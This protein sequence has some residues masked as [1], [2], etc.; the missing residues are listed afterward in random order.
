M[1]TANPETARLQKRLE[2]ER[3]ARREAEALAEKGLRDLYEAQRKVQLLRDIADDANQSVAFEEAIKAAMRRVCTFMDWPLGHAYFLAPSPPRLVSRRI[4]YL[5]EPE[6]FTLFRRISEEAHFAS[7][8]GL[9]GRVLESGQPLW[10]ADVTREANFPRARAAVDI[11][12]RAA[13]AFPVRVGTEVTAVLEFF[14]AQP[15]E[16]AATVLEVMAHIGNQLGPVFKRTQAEK[17]LRGAYAELDERVQERTAE[18]EQANASLQEEIL[19]RKRAEEEEHRAR[20]LAEAAN[21]AKSAFLANMSHELRTPMNAII[22]FSEVLVDETFGELNAKQK[23]YVHNILS[24]GRHL[25]QLINDILDLSKVE[26]GR[27]ELELAPFSVAEAMENVGAIVKTLAAKKGMAL[28]FE[29][30]PGLPLLHADQAKFKQ[31]L[32]NLLSNGIKYTPEGGA[33]SVRA[34]KIAAE[35]QAE[36]PYLRLTV[37][38]TGVGIK[39]EDREKVF[40]EFVQLDDSYARQQQGTGLGL[41]LTRQLVELH[42]GRIRVESAGEGQGSTFV[43]EMPLR[44]DGET[45]AAR[46]V[47]EAGDATAE[48]VSRGDGFRPLVLVVEDDPYSLDLLTHYL[49]QAGYDV[50]QASDGEQ[51]IHIARERKPYA[52]T[53]DI[54]LQRT[55]GWH[56]LA[57]LKSCPETKDIPVVIVSIT[58]DR[59]LG[60]ALGA[61]DY[62]V[63]PV[64]RERLV[65]T[66]RKLSKATGREATRVLV[67][68]D[69]PSTV[70]LLTDVLRSQGY[71]VY[72]A[73]G[74][75]Q[76]IDLALEKRPDAIILDLMMPDVSGCDVVRELR[77]NPATR[78]VPILVFTAATLTEADSAQLSRGV[79]A[80][81]TK[82]AREDLLRGLERVASEKS[83]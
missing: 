60:M 51:A 54:V 74:G 65:E 72:Q 29:A 6:R 80:I 22:G 71:S 41:A 49:T 24:S 15:A 20:E 73:F 61:M 12:V 37:I 16:P 31:I 47:S 8:E 66:I 36:A 82:S 33:V 9:P 21:K 81:I 18:L 62:L 34:Q 63:K 19:Q 83:E 30:D 58:G 75:R 67:V 5:A 42:G 48:P 46:Q 45:A 50:A 17:A 69:E 28:R 78:A 13:F 2:R 64:D 35:T 53:L 39:P 3:K 32:Y 76:G 25:L 26:A 56:V 40:G 1:E 52:I 27:M 4:W 68:D 55:D 23:R 11:G 14:A 43:V 44:S 70:E 79:Q 57:A 7:G 59:Q 38:D 10:I 77:A